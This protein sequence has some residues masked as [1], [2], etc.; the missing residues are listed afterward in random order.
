MNFCCN[1][2]C[3]AQ[4]IFELLDEEPEVDEG[5]VTLVNA[6]DADGT[7]TKQTNM[8]PGHET[9]PLKKMEQQHV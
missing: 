5:Y 9:F 1:G 8:E 4:R 7:F 6:E 3:G 2:T